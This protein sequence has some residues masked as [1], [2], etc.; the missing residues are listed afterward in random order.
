MPDHPIYVSL[1]Q[2]RALLRER[3]ND[4]GLKARVEAGLGNRFIPEYGTMPLAVYNGQ[5]ASADNGF[6]LF[7]SYARYIGAAPHAQE[8][9][10]DMFVTV[11]EEKKGLGRMRVKLEDGTRA[12][13]DIMNF[14]AN[15]KRE[16][17]ECVLE[18]GENL[19]AFHHRLLKLDGYDLVPFDNS[20]W[21]QGNGRALDYY[22]P[23]LL[24][25]VAHAVL[26]ESFCSE[27]GS[28][29]AAFTR[30]VVLP[31]IERIKATVGLA[32]LIVRA[33][34]EDQTD[35]EDFYWWSHSPTVNRYL[36]DYAREHQLKIKP[37]GGQKQS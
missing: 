35:E 5:L 12:T 34:P 1:D 25:F 28:A 27:E 37:W 10:G 22:Y 17:G 13:I 3:W 36:L 26:F 20:A 7:H 2:A 30:N 8:F 4:G 11:N 15:E 9:L 19:A 14:R 33:Y 21:F 32:P 6:A 18:T 29:E 16:I 23:Q 24:H 31:S